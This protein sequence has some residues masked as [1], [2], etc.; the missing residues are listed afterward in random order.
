VGRVIE[1]GILDLDF[2][3]NLINTK[4]D[5]ISEKTD[6]INRKTDFINEKSKTRIYTYMPPKGA[7]VY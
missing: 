3:V 6:F 4:T 5:F 1:K 2:V 7:N